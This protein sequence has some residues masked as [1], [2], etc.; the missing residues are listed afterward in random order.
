MATIIMNDQINLIILNVKK[1][2][3]FTFSANNR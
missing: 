2:K 1:R 3:L